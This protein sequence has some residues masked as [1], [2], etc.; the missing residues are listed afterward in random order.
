VLLLSDWHATGFH[1]SPATMA[2]M[3]NISL[4]ADALLFLATEFF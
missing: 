2:L 1:S 3:N 4:S